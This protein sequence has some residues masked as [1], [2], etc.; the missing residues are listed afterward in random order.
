VPKLTDKE[1]QE[2]K[3]ILRKELER[4]IGESPQGLTWDDI[5]ECFGAALDS[6]FTFTR[7]RVQ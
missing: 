7:E 4:L 5:Q 1:R 6:W 2:A 3:R